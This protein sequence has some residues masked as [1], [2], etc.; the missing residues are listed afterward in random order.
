LN[1]LGILLG[2]VVLAAALAS[3]PMPLALNLPD[4]GRAVVIFPN[5]LF[6]A[7]MILLGALLLLY[8]ATA[9]SKS[10]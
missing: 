2:I 9:N 3:A 7:P 6:A 4:M 1:R 10:H 5:L 8:G